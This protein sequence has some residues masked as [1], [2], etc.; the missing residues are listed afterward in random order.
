MIPCLGLLK[1]LNM[2]ITKQTNQS[3]LSR[4]WCNF[5]FFKL[6]HDNI[7]SLLVKLNLCGYYIPSRSKCVAIMVNQ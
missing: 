6:F 1:M 7:V 5:P 2:A 3:T 4:I